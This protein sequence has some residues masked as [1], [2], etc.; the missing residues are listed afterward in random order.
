MIYNRHDYSKYALASPIATWCASFMELREC[1]KALAPCCAS[2]IFLRRLRNA[3]RRTMPRTLASSALARNEP[4]T[5]I[6]RH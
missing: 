3:L 2:G 1:N 6:S 4:D 5:P